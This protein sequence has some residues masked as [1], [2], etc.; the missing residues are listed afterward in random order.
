[1]NTIEIVKPSVV[2]LTPKEEILDFPRRIE[3]A[4]RTCY[5]SEDK[6]G[7]GTAEKF[8]CMLIRRGH[9]SVLEHCSLSVR[10]VCDRATS[11]QIV[12]HRLC[13]FSQASQRYCCYEGG[14]LEVIRPPFDETSIWVDSVLQAVAAYRA[15]RTAGEPAENARSVLPNC[16]ATQIVMSA[17]VR[18]WRHIFNERA[19]NPHAQLQTRFVFLSLLGELQEL[20][21]CLFGADTTDTVNERL[22]EM[23]AY[24]QKDTETTEAIGERS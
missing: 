6:A 18:Q 16:T 20:V 10:I 2:I 9:E 11:H 22:A 12:R 19:L 14:P 13:A 1:M 5:R 21:P 3:E 23:P 4:G 17:N 7:E 8:C 24:W 15:L